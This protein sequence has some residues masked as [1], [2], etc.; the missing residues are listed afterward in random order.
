MVYL[1]L[2]LYDISWQCP[3]HNV[4]IHFSFAGHLGCSGF[5]PLS[6]NSA[7]YSSVCLLMHMWGSLK[8][9]KPKYLAQVRRFLLDLWRTELPVDSARTGLRSGLKDV[10][11]CSHLYGNIRRQTRFWEINGFTIVWVSVDL[12]FEDC[13]LL[14]MKREPSLR[15]FILFLPSSWLSSIALL[16]SESVGF[17]GP[18][19]KSRRKWINFPWASVKASRSKKKKKKNTSCFVVS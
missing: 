3:F 4:F 18:G 6:N 11:Q 16:R 8:M 1:F 12:S 9:V 7:K 2:W 19:R 10:V 17:V 5:F 15:M 14:L 13:C